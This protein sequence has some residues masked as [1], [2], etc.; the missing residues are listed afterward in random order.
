MEEI[1]NVKRKWWVCSLH[2]SR[3]VLLFLDMGSSTEMAF[4]VMP[5]NPHLI[6]CNFLQK[7]FWVSFKYVLK[8]MACVDNDSP[9]TSH[10]AS[11]A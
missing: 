5:I 10:S 9:S 11:R 7:K 6:A 3:L 8:V 2:L 4:W 1:Y